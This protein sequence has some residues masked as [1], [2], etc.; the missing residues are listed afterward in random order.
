M[1][2]ENTTPLRRWLT[3]NDR[4]NVL[5]LLGCGLKVREIV[6]ITHFS[7]ASIDYIKQAHT[8]CVNQDWS[9]LQRLSTQIRPTVDWAMRVTGTDKVFLETF[10]KEPEKTEE[11]VTGPTVDETAIPDPITREDFVSMYAAMSDIRNLLIEI[12]DILK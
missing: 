10:K 8:A 9:T 11:P 5:K 7:R 6:D 3:D 12:R 2:A 4:D 1:N